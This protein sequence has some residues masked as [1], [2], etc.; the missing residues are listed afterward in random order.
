[1]TGPNWPMSGEIDIFEGV[2]VDDNP[3]ESTL[4]RFSTFFRRWSISLT[5]RVPFHQHTGGTCTRAAS[6]QTGYGSLLNCN[7]LVS[8]SS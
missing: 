5:V 1:M 8:T 4:V 2:N 3:N 7:V 6:N